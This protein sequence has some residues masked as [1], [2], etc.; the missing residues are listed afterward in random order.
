MISNT[1]HGAITKTKKNKRKKSAIY[2]SWYSVLIRSLLLNFLADIDAHDEYGKTPLHYAVG[3]QKLDIVQCLLRYKPD[4]D[5][6]DDRDDTALH[7]AARTGNLDIVLVNVFCSGANYA[8]GGG[9]P[10]DRL[11][12]YVR[13]RRVCFFSHFGHK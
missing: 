12:R 6:H 13:P 8:G 7:A 1:V 3:A 11:Y 5:A 9:T 4:V 10:L 2:S